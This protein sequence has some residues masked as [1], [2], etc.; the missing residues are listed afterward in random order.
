MSRNTTVGYTPATGPSRWRGLKALVGVLVAVLLLAGV[1]VLGRVTAPSAGSSTTV[2]GGVPMRDG[3]PI[4]S[5]HSVSGSATAA[6]DYQIAGFRISAGTLD[7]TTASAVMLAPN[8]S[9]PAKQV[10]VAPTASADQLSKART[11]YAPLSLVM[12]SYTGSQAVVQVWGVAANSTQITPQPAGT[13]DWGRATVTLIWDGGQWRVTDQQFTAGPWPA[14][15]IDRMSSSDGDFSFRY[16]ELTSNGWS[17][18][19][20]P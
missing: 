2:S 18:V 15:D 14:R 4:P 9:D 13:E 12:Q 20:E 6:A 11:T 19:P 16:S 3:V 7:P 1:F 5:R 17:Y 10:L 8:A